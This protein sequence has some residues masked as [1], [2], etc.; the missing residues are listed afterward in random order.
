MGNF[1]NNSPYVQTH[2]GNYY[3]EASSGKL[4]AISTLAGPGW[5]NFGT[6]LASDLVYYALGSH[7]ITNLA[8][9][10]LHIN[11][12]VAVS[13]TIG[14][15]FTLAILIFALTK[16]RNLQICDR[17]FFAA[18]II[19]PTILLAINSSHVGYNRLVS[20]EGRFGLPVSVLAEGLLVA[21]VVQCITRRRHVPI[22]T[23]LAL[24]FIMYP[25][26]QGLSSYL[27]FHNIAYANNE[28]SGKPAT[29]P[30]TF[31]N[32]EESDR[33]TKQKVRE[34][35]KEGNECIVISGITDHENT[36]LFCHD[37]ID[38]AFS[39]KTIKL[40]N[41]RDI[42]NE[43]FNTFGTSNDTTII[44]F[45]HKY[46]TDFNKLPSQP[47]WASIGSGFHFE[48]RK[49]L[50]SAPS[51][52][53]DILDKESYLNL[54]KSKFINSGPIH[55]IDI[56]NSNFHIAYFKTRGNPVEKDS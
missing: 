30:G 37:Q 43:I 40:R 26:A 10:S 42:E 8:N 12:N 53:R 14:I 29:Y 45:L 22:A 49:R 6:P 55:T 44:V 47:S 17:I 20:H 24:A 18:L 36:K 21:Y 2:Y 56:L 4:L 48:P 50:P 46:Y 34:L 31:G 52:K 1:I 54:L 39:R 11:A 3:A 38:L 51:R 13:S 9:D 28:D 15:C 35:S 33:L 25:L 41:P 32:T 19:I 23:I 7:W 27:D 5:L 16:F